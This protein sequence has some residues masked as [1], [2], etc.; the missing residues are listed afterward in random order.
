VDA[1]CWGNIGKRR[2]GRLVAAPGCVAGHTEWLAHGKRAARG[3]TDGNGDHGR[4]WCR[5]SRF[6]GSGKEAANQPRWGIRAVGLG[7]TED[8]TKHPTVRPEVCRW[9]AG[10]SSRQIPVGAGHHRQARGRNHLQNT[11]AWDNTRYP[12]RRAIDRRAFSPGESRSSC[13]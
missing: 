10:Y 6:T 3:G 12:H 9:F 1:R 4:M 13:G 8:T 2:V 7:R 11:L 5:R